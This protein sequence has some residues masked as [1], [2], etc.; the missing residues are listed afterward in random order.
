LQLKDQEKKYNCAIWRKLNRND[1]VI[2]MIPH[3]DRRNYYD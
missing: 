2:K 1:L 3:A